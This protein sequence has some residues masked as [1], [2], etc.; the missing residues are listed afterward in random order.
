MFGTLRRHIYEV[1]MILLEMLIAVLL[2]MQLPAVVEI[3]TVCIGTLSMIYGMYCIRRY[4]RTTPVYLR[5]EP[6]LRR[7]ITL[8]F[9]GF[10][11]ATMRYWFS[12]THTIPY[13]AFGLTLM[14]VSSFKVA[15]VFEAKSSDTPNMRYPVISTLLTFA[16]SLITL[17][18]PFTLASSLW[19]FASAFMLIILTI[20]AYEIYSSESKKREPW[21]MQIRC[22]M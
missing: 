6:E 16:L 10:V 11:I 9:A 14:M 7:G 20:D 3:I 1:I 21:S 2:M 4:Y 19:F 12:G 5:Y 17:A 13:V 18:N 8:L 15:V 22:W